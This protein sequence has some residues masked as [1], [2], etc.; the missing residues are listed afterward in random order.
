MSD[1]IFGM[2]LGALWIGTITSMAYAIF[3]GC[4]SS[5]KWD[6]K[7]FIFLGVILACVLLLCGCSIH[8]AI[9]HIQNQ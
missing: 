1:F 7:S 8:F 3:D 9:T 4:K 2:M 5:K 6:D